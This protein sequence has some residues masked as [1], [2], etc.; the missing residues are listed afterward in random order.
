MKN[1]L[2]WL[3]AGA[4]TLTTVALLAQPPEGGRGGSG[5]FGGSGRGGGGRG[6]GGAGF[7]TPTYDHDPPVLPADLKP[8][9][10]LIYSK[11]NGFREEAGV[12]ASD[13]ALAAIC[14]ERGWPY[15][16]TEN[17]AIMNKEQLAKFKVVVW[18]NNS[19]DTLLPEQREAFKT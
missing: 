2:K 11:T 14:H 4:L 3:V 9:G 6:F 5:A 8:G 10:I 15:Y 17:A 18:N 13:A 12:Q 1:Q 16:V 7:V 19:G